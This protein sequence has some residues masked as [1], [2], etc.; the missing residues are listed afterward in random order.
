MY[1]IEHVASQA[2]TIR[3]DGMSNNLSKT[4]SAMPLRDKVMHCHS[5]SRIDKIND[6]K[7]ST[8]KGKTIQGREGE[9]KARWWMWW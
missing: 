9:R 1:V 2:R 8:V 3:Q 4:N 6:I 5:H 7:V